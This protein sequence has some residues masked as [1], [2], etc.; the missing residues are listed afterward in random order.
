MLHGW[1]PPGLSSCREAG[2]F[3]SGDSELQRCCSGM[4]CGIERC[5]A[6][7][8]AAVTAVEK[9]DPEVS[10]LLVSVHWLLVA[11][12]CSWLQLV[13][14]SE[15]GVAPQRQPSGFAE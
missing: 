8:E 13:A 3:S 4:A 5:A 15:P 9:M 10:V 14:G 2:S 1:W 11:A 6:H 12:G 7:H